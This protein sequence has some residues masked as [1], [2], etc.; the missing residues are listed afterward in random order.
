MVTL[1]ITS[2]GIKLMETS[3]QKVVRW[4]SFSLEPGMFE[5]EMISDPEAL[6]AAIKQLMASSS[7]NKNN[8]I[9]SVSGL[10]SL[11][12]IV[13]IP[14]P[15]G[16]SVTRE[17]VL[18][19]VAHVMPLPEEELYLFWQTIGTGEGGN[20][21]LVVGVPR[22]VLDSELQTLRA[23]GINPRMLDLRAMAL[24]RA[25]NKE[26]ALILNIEPTSFDVV[27]VVDGVPK[28]MRSTAWKETELSADEKCERL[29][30]ALELTVS[31]HDSHNSGISLDPATPLFITGQL[32]GDLPLVE[33]LQTRVA[34]HVELLSPPLEYPAH[35]PVSQYAVNIGLALKNIAQSRKAEQITNSIP[36]MN[37]LPEGYMPWKPSSRQ[38][39]ALCA[40]VVGI[41]LLFPLYQITSLAMDKT[42][43]LKTRYDILN[44][45]LQAMQAEIKSREPLQKAIQ[46]YQTILD[47]GGAFTGNLEVIRSRAAEL[48]I[49]VDSITHTSDAISIN[50]AANSYTA[51]RDYVAALEVSGRFASPIPP[52]EGYPYIKKG[53]IKLTTKAG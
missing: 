27:I 8:V 9:V 14:I 20:R 10:F 44:V 22:D 19:A 6:G 36:D 53:T 16:E 28:V 1:E 46:E 12:R 41:A 32:S 38:I 2:T 13:N 7:I 52:P 24:A 49:E 40:I 34:Y 45:K 50:C 31:Y 43:E 39:Q 29:A 42:A 26:K 35:L 11:S 37:L 23:I 30:S 15:P 21:V 18:E 47:M 33:K 4:A 3:K 5:E 25:V 48:G 51:F 17:A